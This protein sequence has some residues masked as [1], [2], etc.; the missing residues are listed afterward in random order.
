M[1]GEGGEDGRRDNEEG[2]RM[3]KGK[4]CGMREEGRNDMSVECEGEGE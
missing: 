4:L 2:E 3:K 1:R